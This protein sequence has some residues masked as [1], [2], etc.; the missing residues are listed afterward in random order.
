MCWL[1]RFPGLGLQQFLTAAVDKVAFNKKCLFHNFV[2]RNYETFTAL[3][4][5]ITFFI[6]HYITSV[7]F[8]NLSKESQRELMTALQAT[9]PPF[10]QEQLHRPAN[11]WWAHQNTW[12]I[13]GAS[14]DSGGS[15]WGPT[16]QN[17]SITSQQ[18]SRTEKKT[19]Q[20]LD[21]QTC[22]RTHTQIPQYWQ[23]EVLFRVINTL[24]WL[25]VKIYLIHFVNVYADFGGPSL[26]DSSRQIQ[27]E[28]LLKEVVWEP[29]L[30]PDWPGLQNLMIRRGTA[31][32]IF[33][34]LWSHELALRVSNLC[35]FLSWQWHEYS[36]QPVD[37]GAGV[38]L[39]GGLRAGPLCQSEQTV[40]REWTNPA[41]G[42]TSGDRKGQTDIFLCP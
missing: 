27:M 19:E 30:D 7:C 24:L 42:F 41:V 20:W 14:R 32:I 25:T 1:L 28:V 21:E 37:Q 40:G 4:S 18:I 10:I 3:H 16:L 39:A 36:I 2:C 12:R 17:I 8:S 29:Q 11:E 13:T 34:S 38:W 22:F 23:F 6:F 35:L 31:L 5:S 9:I 33:L 15:E 26:E